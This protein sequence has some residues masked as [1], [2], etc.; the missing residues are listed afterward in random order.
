MRF[1][2][3]T[4]QYKGSK[5]QDALITLK[6]AFH[7]YM[8][9][10]KVLFYFMWKDADPSERVLVPMRWGLVPAWFKEDNPSKMQYSTFNCRSDTMMEKLSYRVSLQYLCI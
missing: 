4:V 3:S 10:H 9:W 8:C 7:S 5:L 1:V 2:A 6:F